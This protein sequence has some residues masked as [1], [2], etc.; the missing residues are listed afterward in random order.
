MV[1]IGIDP[2][3]ERSAMVAWDGASIRQAVIAPNLDIVD[4]LRATVFS[5][6]D[7]ILA[8]E[9]IESFGMAV[10]KSVFI[11]C[12]WCGRFEQAWPG[13]VEYVTRKQIKSHICR[14]TRANDSN[15]RQALIDRFGE[16]GKKSAPG[17]TYGLSKD[18]WSAFAVSLT[19]FEQLVVEGEGE[20]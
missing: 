10:G 3:T 17:L 2:G 9:W 13:K 5:E 16:P 14:S 1:I 15:I 20:C 8:I 12:R 11:T 4:S 18:L 6:P 7:I 19:C